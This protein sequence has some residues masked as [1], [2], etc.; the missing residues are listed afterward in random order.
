[1]YQFKKDKRLGGKFERY[2]KTI[3]KLAPIVL[4]FFLHYLLNVSKKQF[5]FI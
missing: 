3:S 2:L 1:M 5:L 4:L